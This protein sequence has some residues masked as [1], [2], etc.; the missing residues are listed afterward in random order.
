[1]STT[2]PVVLV[3]AGSD[4]GGGAG[5]QADMRTLAAHGVFSTTAITALTAQNTQ[6]VHAVHV[7]PVDIV[8]AQIDAVLADFDVRAIKTGMLASAEI[9]KVVAHRAAAGSWS[10]LVVDPVMVSASGDR[11]LEPDAEAS[12]R[13]LLFP[14][15]T[16]I[17][18]N[19]AEA[20]VLLGRNIESV[21]EMGEAAREL[22]ATGAAAV[23][24][25]GGHL[26]ADVAVDVLWDG[27]RLHELGGP[28]VATTN[29]HGTGCSLASAIAAGLARGEELL[30]AVESA[31]AYVCRG[32]EAAVGWRLGQGRGPINHFA[33]QP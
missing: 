22:A 5:I 29:N 6:G 1:M 12:Y 27:S 11:L 17:T 23:V 31:K 9:I 30:P 25:K 19:L 15:A 3:I 16:V 18:P 10:A 20:S 8:A 21:A 4:S 7:A 28:R 24:V 32:L 14:H 2:P 33:S 26:D 13:R